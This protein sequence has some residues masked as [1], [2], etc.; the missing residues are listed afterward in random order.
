[1]NASSPLPFG[2][3]GWG[4]RAVP[5]AASP[6]RSRSIPP[7]QQE[8]YSPAAEHRDQK[9]HRQANE[10]FFDS[11]KPEPTAA[12]HADQGPGH[13]GRAEHGESGADPVSPKRVPHVA[14]DE[15]GEAAGHAAR[16]ARQL[17]DGFEGA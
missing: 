16:G 17:R 10:D 12:D 9:Q 1:M 7:S 8:H 3:R 13:E 11:A 2:E 5:P 6:S 15:Q 4:V 14:A